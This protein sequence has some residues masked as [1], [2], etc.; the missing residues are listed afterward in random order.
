MPIGPSGATLKSPRKIS[1]EF[2]VYIL[3]F[4]YFIVLLRSKI[5]KMDLQKT[6]VELFDEF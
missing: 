5:F 2:E 1:R 6:N 3:K 4:E